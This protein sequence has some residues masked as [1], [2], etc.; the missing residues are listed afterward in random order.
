MRRFGGAQFSEEGKMT[1]EELAVAKMVS[2]AANHPDR[3]VRRLAIVDESVLLDR[4]KLAGFELRGD[5]P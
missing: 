5:K 3:E 1:K 4:I 2:D